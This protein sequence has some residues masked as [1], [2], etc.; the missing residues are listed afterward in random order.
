MHDE[1][2]PDAKVLALPVW[3]RTHLWSELRHVPGTLLQEIAH[4]FS[5]YKDLE[6]GRHSRVEGWEERAQAEEEI[7][8]GRQRLKL[9]A[10]RP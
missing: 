10:A 3:D 2:G 5:V 8:N 1:H 7:R 4:F 9:S 6:T